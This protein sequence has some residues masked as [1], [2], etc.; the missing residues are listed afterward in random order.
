M[1]GTIKS[2]CV[3]GDVGWVAAETS[4]PGRPVMTLYK[5]ITMTLGVVSVEKD[6]VNNTISSVLFYCSNIILI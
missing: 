6:A 5:I 3:F 1:E 4:E 2:T